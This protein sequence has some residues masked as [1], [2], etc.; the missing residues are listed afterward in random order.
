MKHHV[1]MGTAIGLGVAIGL[2]AAATTGCTIWAALSEREQNKAMI[3]ARFTDSRSLKH[4]GIERTY[5][6]H[7][8]PQY[9]K[10]TPMAMVMVFHGGF[11]SADAAEMQSQMTVTADKMGFIAV[12]PEGLGRPMAPAMARSWNGG[13]CCDPAMSRKIDDVGF[14]SDLIDDMAKAYK[15][16]RGRVYATGLSNGAIMSYRLGC[17]LADK[18]AAI[19][20]IDGPNATDTCKPSKPVSLL[21]F[22]GTADPCSPYQGGPGGGCAARALGLQAKPIFDTPSIPDIVADWGKKIGAPPQSRQTFQEAAVTCVTYGP[23]RDGA[24]ATL[25]SLDGYGHTWPGGVDKLPESL[26]GKV[27]HDISANEMMW[28][29]FQKHARKS[30]A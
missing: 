12:Y 19:A 22:H 27:N 10:K 20:P 8:P 9:D 1:S 30:G 24:E 15:I 4:D 28:E 3:E 14:I 6:V 21:H 23:G 13:T 18:I 16:D 7:V 29:F 25:C 5:K 26:V 11:G 17:D 2:G